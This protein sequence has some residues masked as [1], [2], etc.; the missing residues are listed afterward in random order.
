MDRSPPKEHMKLFSRAFPLTSGDEIVISGVSGRFPN[1]NNMHDFAHNLYNKIDMVDDDER[2]WRH[3]NPE[4]PKRMGKVSNLEKF[5]ATFFGVHF[6]QAHT[7]DP[8]CRL[9]LEHAYEA[10]LDAGI[11][12]KTLRGSRTGVFMGACFAES[13]K[14]W[15]YEKVSTG[16]FG[17]TG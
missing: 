16:G 1:S 8:Q 10:V 14:T 9:L 12:P 6:K 7:M 5:D 15:F 2:R 13:E 11:N 4:I 3:T 17:I